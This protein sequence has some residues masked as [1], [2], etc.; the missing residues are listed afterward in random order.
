MFRYFTRNHTLRWIDVLDD[1]V[2][3]YNNR[4]HRSLAYHSPASVTKEN[5]K[6]FWQLQFNDD[7]KITPLYRIVLPSKDHRKLKKHILCKTSF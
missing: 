5:Q 1:L 3:S 7:K 4:G 2:Y 6:Y